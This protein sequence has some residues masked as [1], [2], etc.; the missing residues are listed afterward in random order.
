MNT[1]KEIKQIDNVIAQLKLLKSALQ[2]VE[3]A[4]EKAHNM[5]TYTHTT[6]QINNASIALNRECAELDRCRR[7]AWIAIKEADNLEVSLEV[8]EEYCVSGFHRIKNK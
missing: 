3:K 1:E 4:S 5:S 6:K 2:R 8:P 7:K